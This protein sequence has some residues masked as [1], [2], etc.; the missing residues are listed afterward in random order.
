MNL[1]IQTLLTPQSFSNSFHEKKIFFFMR[2]NIYLRENNSEMT[3]K[4]GIYFRAIPV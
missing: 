1:L 4:T 2:R 3:I